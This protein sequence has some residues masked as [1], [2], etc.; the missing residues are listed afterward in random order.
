GAVIA[1]AAASLLRPLDV[2]EP[3][4]RGAAWVRRE[5]TRPALRVLHALIFIALGLLVLVARDAMVQLALT[6]IGVYLIYEGI[7]AL[8]RLIYRPDEHVEV[9]ELPRVRHRRRLAALA[10]PV[11]VIAIAVAAFV[12]TGR[13][14]TAAPAA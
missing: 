7:V 10:I 11:A 1:A 14:S 13:T 6:A 3:L 12:G 8:L 2:G 5:P 9:I 4:R